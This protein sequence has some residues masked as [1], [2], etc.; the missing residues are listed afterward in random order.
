MPSAEDL[1]SQSLGSIIENCA[2]DNEKSLTE[3]SVDED[4]FVDDRMRQEESLNSSSKSSAKSSEGMTKNGFFDLAKNGKFIDLDVVCT[5][6]PKDALESSNE[7]NV[8]SEAS[9]DEDTIRLPPV[10]IYFTSINDCVDSKNNSDKSQRKDLKFRNRS[11]KNRVDT[12][13]S[14]S[15]KE[16]LKHFF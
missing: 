3:G 2:I 6:A 5:R 7:Q 9:D 1:Y 14:G 8:N 10:R 4:G 11:L 12:L 15:L 13:L 16:K